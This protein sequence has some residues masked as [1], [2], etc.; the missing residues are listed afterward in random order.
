MR[1][2]TLP[3]GIC[4]T[5]APRGCDRTDLPRPLAKVFRMYPVEGFRNFL[6]AE[7]KNNWPSVVL[8]LTFALN[9]TKDTSKPQGQPDAGKEIPTYARTQHGDM[10][11]SVLPVRPTPHRCNCETSRIH[12][13]Y[14]SFAVTS[15]VE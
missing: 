10:T 11:L 8:F 15:H 6:Q 1:N 3:F 14:T 12:K 4:V 9:V 5:I 13:K 7:S 2:N